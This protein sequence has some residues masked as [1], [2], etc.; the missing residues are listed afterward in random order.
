MTEQP[1]DSSYP[2][3]WKPSYIRERDRALDLTEAEIWLGSLSPAELQATL[4]RARG[5]S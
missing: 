5:R 4:T 3:A 1:D 2:A